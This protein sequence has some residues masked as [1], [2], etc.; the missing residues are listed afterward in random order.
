M[1]TRMSTPSPHPPKILRSV[2]N[3]SKRKPVIGKG[4]EHL[5]QEDVKGQGRLFTME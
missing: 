3:G 2:G 5:R 4:I 1:V